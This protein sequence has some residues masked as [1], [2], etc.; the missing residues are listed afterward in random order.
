[1]TD[2][3]Q[4]LSQQLKLAGYS[5]TVPRKLVFDA[6]LH[7]DPMQMSDIVHKLIGHVDR[8]SVYRTID[9]F[10]SL[11]IVQRLHSGWKY[12]IELTDT[13]HD[14]HHHISCQLCGKV[15]DIQGDSYIENDIAQLAVTYGF[16]PISHQLEILGICKTCSQ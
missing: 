11:N 7:Q 6:L 1:M 16:K 9:L 5:T 10:E 3:H 13:F 12:K 2:T 4:Q 8:A 14:H 15:V